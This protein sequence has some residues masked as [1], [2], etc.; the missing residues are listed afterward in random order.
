MD[1][2][3]WL[4]SFSPSLPNIYLLYMTYLVYVL[5]LSLHQRKIHAVVENLLNSEAAFLTSLNIATKAS[6]WAFPP[7][8]F[9]CLYAPPSRSLAVAISGMHL[10]TQSPGG[11]LALTIANLQIVGGRED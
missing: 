3:T 11:L 5:L 6:G 9:Q 10:C 7:R 1:I 8:D 2:I 4:Y